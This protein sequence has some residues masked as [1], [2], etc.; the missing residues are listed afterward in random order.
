M[1]VVVFHSLAPPKSVLIK[2]T[3]HVIIN[4]VLDF[5]NY[6]N[7]EMNETPAL[8]SLPYSPFFSNSETGPLTPLF[9]KPSCL[10]PL[11]IPTSIV[12][13]WSTA[14]L[15]KLQT[16][17]HHSSCSTWDPIHSKILI[18]WPRW[19]SLISDSL[20]SQAYWWSFLQ[21]NQVLGCCWFVCFQCSRLNYYS[22]R[23]PFIS[24]DTAGSFLGKQLY[25]CVR[26]TQTVVICN[27]DKKI[28][29]VS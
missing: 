24:A 18:P 29:P 7:Y 25:C 10:C 5:S 8:C 3:V 21:K 22:Q 26:L 20:S 19:E 4:G 17:Q 13:T 2:S 1:K 11:P 6:S 12:I 14:T 15:R 16:G 23:E 27:K 28:A 9:P